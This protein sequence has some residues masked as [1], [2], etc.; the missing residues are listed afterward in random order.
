[1]LLEMTS[2]CRS[3]TIC[4]DN[5]T[6]SA[7]SIGGAPLLLRSASDALPSVSANPDEPGLSQAVRFAEDRAN[8]V[9]SGKIQ[10]FESF[11][12]LRTPKAGGRKVLLTMFARQLFPSGPQFE[13]FH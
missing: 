11:R 13:R 8:A 7:F 10:C 5:P 2:S 3:R 1:M 12:G 4:R 6:R 9:P